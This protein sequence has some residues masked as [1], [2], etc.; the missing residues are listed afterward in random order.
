MPSQYCSRVTNSPNT[1]LS[2]QIPDLELEVLVGDLLHVEADGGY[3]GDHLAHLQS[4]ED[5]GLAGAVQAQDQ[6]AHLPGAE[7]SAK[8]AEHPTWKKNV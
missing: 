3:R 1:C 4:V 5:R 8:V 6:D 7:Q 2:A